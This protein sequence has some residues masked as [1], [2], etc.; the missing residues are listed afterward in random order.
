MLCTVCTVLWA[1][2]SAQKIAAAAE[3]SGAEQ[4]EWNGRG[5]RDSERRESE[6]GQFESSVVLCRAVLCESYVHIF[7]YPYSVLSNEYIIYLWLHSFEILIFLAALNCR[8]ST[9][10]HSTHPFFIRTRAEFRWGRA[11]EVHRLVWVHLSLPWNSYPFLNIKI[12]RSVSKNA[13][14]ADLFQKCSKCS[15][16]Y[17][18]S[19]A[20]HEH[21]FIN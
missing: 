18:L 10:E 4:P 15:K 5:R 13:S 12:L 2:C 21:F 1:I 20:F 14:P 9:R 6:K 7:L 3:Q 16:Y 17:R 19:S 11:D 8:V